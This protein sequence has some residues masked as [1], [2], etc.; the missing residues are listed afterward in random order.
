VT[1]PRL[2][3]TLPE[4]PH[5]GDSD[6]PISSENTMLAHF[7]QIHALNGFYCLSFQP[8]KLD[9]GFVDRLDSLLETVGRENVL[10]STAHGVTEVWRG[11]DHIRMATR[12]MSSSRTSLK[13]S[14]TGTERVG[15][16]AM[17]IEMPRVI[18]KLDIESMTLGTALPDS[19]SHDGI[20]WKLYLDQLSAGKNVTY[21]LD[22]P[23]VET[24]DADSA[25]TDAPSETDAM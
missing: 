15:D 12:H 1:Q 10:L 20:R 11:W 4:M 19:L 18:S 25:V 6:S 16:I 17:Y 24:R 3:W 5:I 2:L 21:Y 9:V 14:N 23:D 13:I 7:A 22:L 8:S